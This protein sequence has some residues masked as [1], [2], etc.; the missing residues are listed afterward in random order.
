MRNGEKLRPIWRKLR[1]A[2]GVFGNMAFPP[3]CLFCHA[4][5]DAHHTLC[6]SCWAG[7]EFIEQPLCPLTGLPLPYDAGP[8]FLS[9]TALGNPPSYA[10]ARAVM[11]YGG[12]GAELVHHFKY[13]DGLESAPM[14]G[15]WMLRAGQDVLQ[16]ADFIT[17]VPLHRRRLFT[18]RFNQSAELA[19]RLSE[20]S[21]LNYAPQLLERIRATRP[22]VGLSETAR[23]RNVAGAFQA[24]RGTANLVKDR[25]IVLIDDVVTTGATVEACTKALIRA[26]AKEVRVLCLAR[27]VP[28]ERATI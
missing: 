8:G 15:R 2:F 11:R 7:V 22:Q 25:I 5:V 13:A 27:V 9:A 10:A 14:F 17:P 18:R 20:L 12:R 3:L 23:R 16:G 4:E 21:G 6:S 1:G 26:G 19:R 28:E 24:K